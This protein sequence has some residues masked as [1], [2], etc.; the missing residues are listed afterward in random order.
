MSS[1]DN[2]LTGLAKSFFGGI[3]LGTRAITVQGYQEANVKNGVQY[4]ASKNFGSV[5]GSTSIDTIFTTGSLPVALK[6]RVVSFTGD[7]VSAFIFKAPSFTG[8]STEAFQNATDIN[9]VAGGIT[10]TTGVTLTDDGT[11]LFAPIHAF[12]NSSNQ[13]K[14]G[15]LTLLEPEQILAPNTDYLLRLTS[16]DASAQNIASHLRWYEGGL[17]LPST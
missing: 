4:E 6:G 13:G 17:D 7:G 1:I 12:G 14:G 8:G 3:V 10:I 15:I 5:A 2:F 16:L 11:L 9:P